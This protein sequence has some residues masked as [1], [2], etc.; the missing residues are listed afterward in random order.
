M[1]KKLITIIGFVALLVIIIVFVIY[2]PKPKIVEIESS[3]ENIATTTTNQ[4]IVA[5]T[6]IDVLDYQ[7]ELVREVFD[8]SAPFGSRVSILRDGEY[9]FTSVEGLEYLT[10]YYDET[11]P[12][13]KT[14][15]DL[16][17]AV[18][19]ITGN[20]I[21]ELYIRGWS[22]GSHCCYHNYIIELSNPLSILFDVD[23]E[24]FKIS[25]EDL[26]KDGI[27]EILTN[28]SKFSYW[29]TYY[30]ASPR[31]PVILS[32]QEGK[33]KADPVFM[34]KP[35]PTDMEIRELA[36]DVKGWSGDG[37]V[38]PTVA[39]EYAV[40]LIYS[41]NIESARKYVDLAWR[42]DKSG[43]F[44]TK[45]IFWEELSSQ[46]KESPYYNDLEDFFGL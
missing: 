42:D 36:N 9:L 25:F 46:I 7:I 4:M 37:S 32:L 40:D 17:K 22:G 15:A 44:K 14:S 27:M 28:E 8:D 18:K 35:A 11:I 12:F 24:D 41:G 45:D 26:D 1:N 31:P 19:D 38:G 16:K 23:T 43:D 39:W 20:G 6:T 5:T 3:T 10:F 13:L 30:V 2:T 34:R 33:Y 21:P 29:H